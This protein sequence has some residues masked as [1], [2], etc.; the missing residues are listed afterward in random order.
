MNFKGWRKMNSAP[1]DGTEV[2]ILETPNGV[3]FNTMVACFMALMH[4]TEQHEWRDK[5]NTPRAMWWGS[6]PTHWSGNG[7]HHTHWKP[8][9]CHPLCWK[10]LPKHR[11]SKKEL[12]ALLEF[13]HES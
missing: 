4:D 3:H 6:I 13:T 11:F 7:P 8:I 1:K 10:P 9:A 5:D 2:I 12:H